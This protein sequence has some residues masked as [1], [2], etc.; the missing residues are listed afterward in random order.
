M[1]HVLHYSC[2]VNAA[3]ADSLHCRMICGTVF[4]ARLNAP[5]DGSDVIA[6]GSAFQI[7]AAATGKA[8]SPT[9]LCKD[10]GTCS[11][12]DDAD[13]AYYRY[14]R[15]VRRQNRRITAVTAVLP[16]SPLQCSSLVHIL[17]LAACC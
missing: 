7:F 1:C 10:R 6:G 3:V 14:Y 8:R 4:S 2:N 15:N 9:V 5:S 13:P 11:D 16:P 12:G 17:P